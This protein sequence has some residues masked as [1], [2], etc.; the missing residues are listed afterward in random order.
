MTDEVW[1]DKVG[2]RGIFFSGEKILAAFRFSLQ[3]YPKDV[4]TVFAFF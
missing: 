4:F 3:E 2:K 1:V